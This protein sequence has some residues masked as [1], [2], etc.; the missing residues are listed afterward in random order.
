MVLVCVV[1]LRLV[2][3]AASVEFAA[4]APQLLEALLLPARRGLLDWLQSAV[5]EVAAVVAVD[6]V[7]VHKGY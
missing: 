2:I 7:V 1:S 5:V 6:M 4:E 3:V